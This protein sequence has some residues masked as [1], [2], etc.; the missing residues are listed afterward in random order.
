MDFLRKIRAWFRTSEFLPEYLQAIAK[1][2]TN[3]LFGESILAV[4]F[5]LWWALGSPPLGLIFTSGFILAGYF[6]WLG[7]HDDLM[8]CRARLSPKFRV[9]QTIVQ[10]TPT[11]FANESRV[12]V[13]I[14]PECLTDA[15][16]SE[17]RG[18]LLRVLRMEGSEWVLTAADEPLEL[19]WSISDSTLPR[20]INPGILTRLNL[21]W[22]SNLQQ[23]INLAADRIP[24]RFL[25]VFQRQEIFRF[26]VRF[27]ASDC[28][29]V[30][31]SVAVEVG[32]QWND[33]RASVVA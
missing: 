17:C 11:N 18:T 15:P 29:P 14:I 12:Y 27:T 20:M 5:L 7:T 24:F 4:I 32:Q 21:V 8:E 31:V 23:Q 33:I 2:W 3:I 1:E 6:A 25:G 19:T 26:D 13:Q 30:D 10:P 28:A 9:R 16:V 22:V